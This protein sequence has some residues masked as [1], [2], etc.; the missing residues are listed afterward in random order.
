MRH[1]ART[2]ASRPAPIDPD[3]IGPWV[4]TATGRMIAFDRPDLT[5]VTIKDVA[6]GLA[7]ICRFA[8]AVREFYSVAQHSVLVAA[9]CARHGPEVAQA[10]LLHDAH[11]IALGDIPAPAIAAIED[12]AGTDVVHQIKRALDAQIHMALGIAYPLPGLARL[13]IIEADRMALA[14][15]ARDLLP[16]LPIDDPA[17]TAGPRMSRPVAPWRRDDPA[18]KFLDAWEMYG[19]KR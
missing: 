14:T 2:R 10:A 18:E 8:G 3:M 7:R 6:L 19:G 4:V 12:M 16:D 11:E 15:E 9:I 5:R 13:A 1:P 17:L